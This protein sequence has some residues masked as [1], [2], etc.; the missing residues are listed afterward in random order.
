VIILPTRY[1]H[2]NNPNYI[3]KIA[4][5]VI[6]RAIVQQYY[7]KFVPGSAWQRCQQC[8]TTLGNDPRTT[9]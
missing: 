1:V 4:I 2:G 3:Q 7:M 8:I 6:W 5:F 9:L